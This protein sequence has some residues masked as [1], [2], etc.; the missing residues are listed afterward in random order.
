MTERRKHPRTRVLKGAK[1]VLGPTSVLDC[2]IRDLTNGGARLKA[3][4]VVNL[5]GDVALTFDS[6][7]TFRPGRVAWRKVEEAG[8]EFTTPVQKNAG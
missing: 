5:P 1:I 8:L 2:V 7:R 3:P 4:N 6:G